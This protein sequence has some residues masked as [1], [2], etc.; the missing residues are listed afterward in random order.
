MTSG[1]KLGCIADDFTGATDLA[2]NL[3]RAGM[4]VVQ[5]I[6]VPIAAVGDVDALVV[7]LKSRT[8]APHEAIEQSLAALRWLRAQGCP[9]FYFKICSTFDSTPHGNIGPVAEAL[10]DELG[11]SFAC[12][13]P[14][15]PENAR[16]V[17]QG[18][19]FVG[20]VPLAES[21]MRHHP[22]T[23]MTDSNLVRVLQAQCSRGV[24]L[25]A[26]EAVRGG[27]EAIRVRIA[28]LQSEGKR[29][30]IVD[31]IRSGDLLALA[32]A[33]ADAPLV[34]A[35]SGVAI[36]LPRNHGL[37]PSVAAAQ[38]PRSRGHAAIVSGSCSAATNAQVREFVASG[39]PA[40][41]IDPMRIA[42]GERVAD[43]ALRWARE[44]VGE[45][46]LLVYSTANP[47]DVRRVQSSL[48]ASAV[49]EM[50]EN[51]LAAI[52]KGLVDFGVRG[53]SSRA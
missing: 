43:E 2:N 19:L 45:Q 11:A 50:V 30:A 22:L 53:S 26:H 34:V 15:F 47:D 10:M 17:Y 27:P 4:R 33:V 51:V 28:E 41:A 23:P 46:A 38:L 49:G 24:G 32:R 3:V 1:L 14:A 12:V 18:H 52:A 13:T 39:A 20:D 36:G 48:G 44:H 37:E 5:T 21:G 8:I 42:A 25:V 6:G 7:A 9:Q 35:G 31:A 16:T 29:F 40:F